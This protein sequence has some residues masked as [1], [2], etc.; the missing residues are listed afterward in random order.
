MISHS[1]PKVKNN[2]KGRYFSSE[3]NVA[4]AYR[5]RT[6]MEAFDQQLS[7]TAKALD[8]AKPLAMSQYRC[9]R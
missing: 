4:S 1:V 3:D 8:D 6:G 2:G 9:G 5:V 7:L